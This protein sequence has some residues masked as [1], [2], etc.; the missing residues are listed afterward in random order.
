MAVIFTGLALV[1]C[2]GTLASLRNS[3]VAAKPADKSNQ[4]RTK[5]PSL[6]SPRNTNSDTPKTMAQT[7]PSS[8]A[9]ESSNALKHTEWWT[10]VQKRRR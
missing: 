5:Q 3:S 1:G 6:L 10:T 9:M 7:Q 8:A 2:T 4:E